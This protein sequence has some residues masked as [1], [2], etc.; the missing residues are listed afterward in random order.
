MNF[1]LK[2]VMYQNKKMR[3]QIERNEYKKIWSEN[4]KRQRFKG[5]IQDFI[6]DFRIILKKPF[7][8]EE[9]LNKLY[10]LVEEFDKK[11]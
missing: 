4:A 7:S 8:P 3:N 1:L 6:D 5:K 2:M 9:K 10:N 11:F